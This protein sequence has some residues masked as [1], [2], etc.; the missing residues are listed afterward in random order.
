M[1][2]QHMFLVRDSGGWWSLACVP[3]HAFTVSSVWDACIPVFDLPS[4]VPS[5]ILPC[6]KEEV[7]VRV[8]LRTRTFL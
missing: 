4:S 6:W 7:V 5:S 3:L 8:L 1:P 2:L